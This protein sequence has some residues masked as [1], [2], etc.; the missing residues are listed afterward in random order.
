MRI[1][2]P[3]KVYKAELEGVPIAVKVQRPGMADVIALDFYLLRTMAKLLRKYTR[4]KSDPALLVDDFGLRLF[5]ELDYVR[6]SKNMAQFKLLY[7]NIKGI[8]VPKVGPNR[9][10]FVKASRGGCIR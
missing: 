1:L 3:A 4:S 8:Y 5:E 9:T 10:I 7:G 6:E 2:L